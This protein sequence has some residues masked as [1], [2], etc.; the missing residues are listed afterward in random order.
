MPPRVARPTVP[1]SDGVVRLEPLDERFAA[2]LDALAT[3]P[4]VIRFTRVPSKPREGFGAT[5]IRAYNNGWD[6]G[7]RAGF[8]ILD[9][10][11]AGFLGM[12]AFVQLEHE[13]HQGEIGYIVAPAA[14]GRGVAVRA[15]RVL[16]A[17]GFSE[18]GLERI[19]AWIDVGNDVSKRVV[20]R[21]G[22]ACGG[23]EHSVDFKEGLRADMA[24]YSLRAGELR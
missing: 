4:D 9:D 2:A 1:L 22:F 13:S 7:S 11:D 8:A 21:V 18:L 12:A 16:A 6:D 19:E 23:V 20:E 10:A 17:W 14:R 15:I 24:V 5:W 3:D